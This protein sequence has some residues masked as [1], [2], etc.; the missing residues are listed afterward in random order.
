[1]RVLMGHSYFLH[2]DPKLEAAMQ[3]YPPLG[4]LLAA[5]QLREAG[6][7]V[8]LFDPMLESSTAPWA[9]LVESAR[10]DVAVL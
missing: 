10:P 7:E 8:T 1:M 6:H 3:P 2:F 5:A 9:S 4:T